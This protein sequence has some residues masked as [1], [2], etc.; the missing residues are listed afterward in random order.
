MKREQF[1]RRSQESSILDAVIRKH[2]Q[3]MEMPELGSISDSTNSRR[4]RIFALISQ[5]V[6]AGVPGKTMRRVLIFDNHSETLRLLLKSGIYLNGTDAQS[7]SEKR[8]S[9][10]CGSIL[11]AMIIAPMF[12]L[13][14]S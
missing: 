13:L 1:D 5:P 8:Q 9:I 12:W 3:W 2:P 14:F 10:I 6:P 7:C 4:K 11:I